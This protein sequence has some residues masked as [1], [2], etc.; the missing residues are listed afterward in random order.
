REH[1]SQTAEEA[2][3]RRIALGRPASCECGTADEDRNVVEEALTQ[4]RD[5]SGLPAAQMT[6]QRLGPH[7]ERGGLAQ[8]M[9]TGCQGQGS[10]AV[11]GEEVGRQPA[12]PRPGIGK[13]QDDTKPAGRRSPLC[14]QLRELAVP[15]YEP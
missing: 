14:L 11:A 10:R 1:A 7:A 9:G 2:D 3:L 6:L 15:I 12:L 13:H 5:V 8:G 4:L